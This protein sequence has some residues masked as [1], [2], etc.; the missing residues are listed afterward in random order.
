MGTV[1]MWRHAAA[2]TA[3]AEIGLGVAWRDSL[4][5]ALACDVRIAST[6]APRSGWC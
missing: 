1:A 2:A 5:I 6:R 4:L 3:V